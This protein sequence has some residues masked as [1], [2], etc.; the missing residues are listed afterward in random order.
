MSLPL[1]AASF[2]PRFRTD[3][4]PSDFVLRPESS[5]EPPIAHVRAEAPAV[6]PGLALAPQPAAPAGPPADLRPEPF[7]VLEQSRS[8]VWPL[9]LALIVGIAL[10]FAAGYGLGPRERAA[11]TG[12]TAGR[13]LAE[14]ESRTEG[15]PDT[16]GVTPTGMAPAAVAP[17]VANASAPSSKPADPPPVETAPGRVLV[18]SA[19]S[20]ARVVVDGRDHGTTPASIQDLTRG[21]HRVQVMRDGYGTEERR[22]VI[23]RARPTLSLNVKLTR[24]RAPAP[25]AAAPTAAP[26]GVA[27]ALIV[28]S[29]P[30][31]AQVFLDGKLLGVTPLSLASVPAGD[32]A[33]HLDRGGY[34]RWSSS[35]RIG[36]SENNRVTA[37]LE[38]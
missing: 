12:G 3:E 5:S 1:A 4:P 24:E 14:G 25:R 10:G 8:A 6:V 30:P 19:P 11:T 23:T 16:T 7:S 26:P 31:G 15:K 28:E 17:T 32:H 36:A 33:I 29:R 13:E 35:V 34:R 2:E 9:I 18:R 27:G 22:V 38:K 21:S 37:S 20:G